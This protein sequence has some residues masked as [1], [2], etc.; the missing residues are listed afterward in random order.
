MRKSKYIL[1]ILLLL[2][3]FVFMVS[4]EEHSSPSFLQFLGKSIN[5]I[6]LFGGLAYI[7]YKPLRNFLEKRSAEIECSQ[8]E[9]EDARREA[10]KK[11]EKAKAQLESLE[12]EVAEIKKE[13]EIEGAREKE[14]ILNEAKKEAERIKHLV[15]TEIDVYIEAGIR[16]LKEYAAEMATKLA[17]E[18]IKKKM[19]SQDHS[20]LIDKSIEKLSKIDEKSGFDKKIH[21]RVS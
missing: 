14:R 10:E 19:T 7:L 11:L 15:Q 2:P 4:E 9:A 12:D 16:E 13:A 5:F 1:L 6:I 20:L 8:K 21:S 18:R 3:L 17:Q